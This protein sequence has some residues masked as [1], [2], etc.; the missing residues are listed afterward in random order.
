[1]Q[2]NTIG[3]A[4]SCMMVSQ[5]ELEARR[6]AKVAVLGLTAAFTG[7]DRFSPALLGMALSE[8]VKNE[9]YKGP[10]GLLARVAL[11]EMIGIRSGEVPQNVKHEYRDQIELV[12][13]TLKFRLKSVRG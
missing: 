5:Q 11:E 13:S 7:P 10:I 12:E 8:H 3:I 4:R 2:S 1:M 6:T 9:F